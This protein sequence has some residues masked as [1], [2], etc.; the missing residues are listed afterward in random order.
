MSQSR[1]LK[2]LAKWQ[3]GNQLKSNSLSVQDAILIDVE[4]LLNSQQGNI[5]IDE[6]MGLNDLQ[7]HFNSHGSPDLDDLAMQI[8]T[9]I[10]HYEPR[11]KSVSLTL[12]EEHKDL[13]SFNWRLTCKTNNEL[14]V[15]ALININADGRVSIKSAI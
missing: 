7:G 14:D 9:Q 12:D 2:R 13:S 4:C 8:S 6:N 11:L 5:L 1:L 10:T 15:I 3:K